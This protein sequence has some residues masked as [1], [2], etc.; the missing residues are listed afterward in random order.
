MTDPEY[1]EGPSEPVWWTLLAIIVIGFLVLLLTGCGKKPPVLQPQVIEIIKTVEVKVP[2]AV[3]RKSPAELLAPIKA[4]LPVFVAPSDPAATSA[5]TAE[6]ERNLLALLLDLL[7]RIEAW[8]TWA[9][10]P[11]E[12]QP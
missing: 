9:L 5:L 3:E 8:R 11:A 10:Q 12:R 2:V 6:G 7:G 4:P 1:R